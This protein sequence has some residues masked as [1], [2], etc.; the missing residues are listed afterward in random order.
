VIL[1][2]KFGTCIWLWFSEEAK[3]HAVGY[4]WDPKYGLKSLEDDRIGEM[5]GDWGAE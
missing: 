4:Y 5:L 1:E 2:A 3:E